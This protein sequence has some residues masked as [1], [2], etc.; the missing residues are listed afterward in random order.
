[1]EEVVQ[2]VRARGR[3]PRHGRREA[4]RRR[5]MA[6]DLP[7]IGDGRGTGGR[8]STSVAARV[9]ILPAVMAHE[10]QR[11]VPR[12]RGAVPGTQAVRA[13]AHVRE[14][15]AALQAALLDDAF[16]A[17]QQLRHQ[18]RMQWLAQRQAEAALEQG[19]KEIEE[20]EDEDAPLYDL[21][22]AG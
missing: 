16:R 18:R 17:A 19:A 14:L 7:A 9:P 22:P 6:E 2:A 11:L 13:A 5:L 8:S 10:V 20:E 12:Q 3:V 4:L 1:M 21:A 15:Q